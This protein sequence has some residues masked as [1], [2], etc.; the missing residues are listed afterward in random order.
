MEGLGVPE[1]IRDR[2]GP[3]VKCG[4]NPMLQGLGVHL[5]DRKTSDAGSVSQQLVFSAWQRAKEARNLE[6]S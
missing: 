1:F 5:P 2:P 6:A 4:P 3:T